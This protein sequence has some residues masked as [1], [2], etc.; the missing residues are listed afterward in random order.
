MSQAAQTL[1]LCHLILDMHHCKVF[2][3]FPQFYRRN[4][5]VFYADGLHCLQFDWQSVSIPARYIWGAETAHVF[6]LYNEV[7]QCLVQGSSQVNLAVRIRR[8]IVKN[9]FRLSL[10]LGD[11]LLIQILVFPFL[12]GIRFPF[13]QIS[14]HGKICLGQI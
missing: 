13:R 11:H 3:V 6:I 2:A 7:F 5:T 14:T 10:I 12:Q 9:V 1:K 8:S 4:C